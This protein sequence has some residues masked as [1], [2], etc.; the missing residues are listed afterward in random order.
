MTIMLRG[1]HLTWHDW[2]VVAGDL[3]AD[4]VVLDPAHGGHGQADLD[5]PKNWKNRKATDQEFDSR[6]FK[7][8]PQFRF[9]LQA[10]FR[11]P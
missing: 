3:A 5:E 7:L 6:K 11:I 2:L 9:F 10:S 8:K 4:V 1:K